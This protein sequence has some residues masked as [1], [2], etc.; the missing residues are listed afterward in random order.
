MLNWNADEL[1]H[2]FWMQFNRVNPDASHES[3]NERISALEL[4]GLSFSA[5]SRKTVL[6][7]VNKYHLSYYEGEGGVVTKKN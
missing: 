2:H 1:E 6:Q 4:T 5:A 3:G 7:I